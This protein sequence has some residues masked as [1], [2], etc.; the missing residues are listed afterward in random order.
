MIDRRKK[1]LRKAKLVFSGNLKKACR[2]FNS[3]MHTPCIILYSVALL[4]TN[5]FWLG[6]SMYIVFLKKKFR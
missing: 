5:V 6:I 1:Y 4:Q 3:Q 2:N